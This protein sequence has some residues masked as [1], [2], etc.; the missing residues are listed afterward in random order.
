MAM[1]LRLKDFLHNRIVGRYH[2]TNLEKAPADHFSSIRSVGILF[3]AADS[4]D[5]DI[6]LDYAEQLRSQGIQ[7][8]PLGYFNSKVEGITFKFDFIDLTKLSFAFIPKGERVK[9]FIAKPFDLL[10]NLDSSLHK[11]LNYI[12]AASKALFKIG[13]ANGNH[14]HYDLMIEMQEQDISKYIQEIRKTFNKISG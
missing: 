13:P 3:D 11:P 10:V 6:V 12:A 4:R 1:M 5:R 7:V 8:W 2:E 9:E 14:Q